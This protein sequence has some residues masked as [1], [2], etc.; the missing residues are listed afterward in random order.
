MCVKPKDTYEEPF[1][2]FEEQEQ[3]DALGKGL[4]GLLKT[5]RKNLNFFV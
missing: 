2:E 3:R 5:T 4:F 1:A